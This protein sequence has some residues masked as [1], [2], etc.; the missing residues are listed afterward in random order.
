MEYYQVHMDCFDHQTISSPRAAWSGGL[1]LLPIVEEKYFQ[2]LPIVEE[3]YFFLTMN[4]E[5]RTRTST[6]SSSDRWG[7]A[8]SSRCVSPCW[9]VYLKVERIQPFKL[10]GKWNVRKSSL[11]QSYQWVGGEW[12]HKSKWANCGH[13]RILRIPSRAIM[14]VK[15]EREKGLRAVYLL[16]PCFMPIFV[17]REKLENLHCFVLFC[18]L[19]RFDLIWRPFIAS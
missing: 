2:L 17:S 19:L 9:T 4:N 15:Y 10:S 12:G 18:L 7:G 3:K 5:E 6:S 11:L 13:G 16:T 8:A 14:T 1:R